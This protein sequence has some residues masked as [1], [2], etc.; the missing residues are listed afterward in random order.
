MVG[1]GGGVGDSIRRRYLPS[2]PHP[3]R[4]KISSETAEQLLV[5]IATLIS[6]KA[7]IPRGLLRGA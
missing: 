7:S 3:D 1:G 4:R 2:H 5:A 6:S